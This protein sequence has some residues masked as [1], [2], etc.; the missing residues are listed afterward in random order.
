M[1]EEHE[2]PWTPLSP[3]EVARVFRGAP[4]SWWLAGGYAIERF[5]GQPFRPHADIDVLVLRRDHDALRRHLSRWDCWAADPPG[6]LRPW[7]LNEALAQPIHDIWCRRAPDVP[8]SLQL[9]LDESE[10][11]DWRSRRNPAIGRP[12]AELGAPDAAG[13]PL[14]APE[15]QLFYK[16]K[17]PRPKDEIDFAVAAPLLAPAQSAWLRWAIETTHGP[18]HPWL[19][20][21]DPPRPA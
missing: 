1:P 19:Q 6:R 21:L 8:W 14:L 11:E 4:F 15:I 16:A 10:G 13:I 7:P 17:A 18:A 9:M 5:I 20:K 2:K 3:E 12:I